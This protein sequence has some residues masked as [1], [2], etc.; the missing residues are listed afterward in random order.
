VAK[1]IYRMEGAIF[2]NILT[3]ARERA[4]LSQARLAERLG[5]PQSRIARIE[6]NQRRLDFV[7]CYEYCAALGMSLSDLV[8]EFERRIALRDS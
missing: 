2:S 1:S 4:G 5:C 7:E 8:A 6:T 3:E